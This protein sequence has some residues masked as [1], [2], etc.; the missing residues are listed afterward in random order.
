MMRPFTLLLGLLALA[1]PARADEQWKSVS[2]KDGIR[3][4]K[5]GVA[6]SKFPEVR[7]AGHSTLPPGRL[8]AAIWANRADGKFT[9]KS[10]RLRQVISETDTVR[11]VYEQI[12]TPLVSDRDFTARLVRSTDA[13]GVFHVE[14][15]TVDEGPPPNPKL[16]RL[17][18]VHG[19]WS[20]TPAADGGCDVVYIV[21]SE[22][23]GSIPAWMVRGAQI[24][25]AGD[26][27][28]EVIDW[29][30]R[31]PEAR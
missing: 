26:V 31:H 7:A 25:T 15:T 20:V 9:R 5:R 23:G 19:S 3:V 6:G 17:P 11:V 8:A 2:D 14:F 28:V 27:V 22:P 12:R 30:T 21:Y 24:D 29:A 16:V 13:K 1:V 10:R 4:E 18:R